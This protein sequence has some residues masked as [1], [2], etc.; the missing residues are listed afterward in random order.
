M[1]SAHCTQLTLIGSAAIALELL[2]ASVPCAAPPLLGVK[3]IVAHRGSS[4][5]R[6]ENTLASVR[7]AIEAGA[8]AVEVDVRST[9]DGHLVILH[10]ATLD[11][12]TNG[13]GPVA[14]KTLAEVR[15]L[16]AGSWF[17]P[18]YRDER[19]PTLKEVLGVCRDRVDVLIDLKE[20][21]DDFAR[22]VAAEVKSHG[23]PK[24][25]I[26][27]VRST[28]Q[29]RLFH[30]LLPEARQL[31]LIPSP[32]MI[33]SFAE[34]RVEMIRLW[35]KWLSEDTSLARRVRDAG[36]K[37]HLNGST[38]EPDEIRPLLKF[39]PDSLSSDDPARLLKTLG[40]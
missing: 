38:G 5:D 9:R 29:A 27:G 31:G 25:T 34:A 3:Q 28:E 30:Q 24:Q 17:A 36:A 26:M 1:P 19:I 7:R 16:E 12:T 22:V 35:P 20:E 11:R 18:E 21:G 15:Q 6:P 2:L 23:S 4:A 13:A 14:E 8:T 10:D 32:H 40:P 37:L 33:E 39:K